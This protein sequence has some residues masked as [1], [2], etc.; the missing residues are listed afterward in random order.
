VIKKKYFYDQY[1]ITKNRSLYQYSKFEGKKFL[2]NFFLSRKKF[3][4][5]II[6]FEVKFKIINEKKINKKLITTYCTSF[7][8]KK[9]IYLDVTQKKEFSFSNYVSL[10]YKISNYLLKNVDYSM[11]STFLKINDLII[12]QYSKKKVYNNNEL[13]SALM[14][15]NLILKKLINEKI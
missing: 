8:K 10:S 14:A 11:L 12:Y 5:K 7:E 3:L 4:K 13:F 1:D 6:K 2:D 9:K 15:E